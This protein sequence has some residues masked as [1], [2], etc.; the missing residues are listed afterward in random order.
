MTRISVMEN[1]ITEELILYYQETH[2]L[3]ATLKLTFDVFSPESDFVG[4]FFCAA[5]V[6]YLDRRIFNSF[7]RIP[8]LLFP[9]SIEFWPLV[10]FDRL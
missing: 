2:F 3:D 1:L 8:P 5:A 4:Y 6:I 9:F 7:L 10:I